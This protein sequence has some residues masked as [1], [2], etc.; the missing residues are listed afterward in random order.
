MVIWGL[1]IDCL[2]MTVLAT[3]ADEGGV[4]TCLLGESIATLDLRFR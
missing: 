4:K 2:A 1:D 3:R